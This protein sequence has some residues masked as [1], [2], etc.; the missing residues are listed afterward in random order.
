MKKYKYPV[1]VAFI[2]W[3]FILFLSDIQY[4]EYHSGLRYFYLLRDQLFSVRAPD[5]II[6]IEIDQATFLELPAIRSC[7]AKYRGTID[8]RCFSRRLHG[9]LIRALNQQ[10]AKLIVFNLLFKEGR[11]D[12][13]R[14]FAQ[15][16]READN[17]LLQDYQEKRFIGGDVQIV[18][19][20]PPVSPLA[21][22]TLSAPLPIP[23]GY[24]P[25]TPLWLF[26]NLI[27]TESDAA[28]NITK[29]V[30]PVLAAHALILQ[31]YPTQVSAVLQEVSPDLLNPI[32]D[33]AKAYVQGKHL[34]AF[35]DH[36]GDAFRDKPE[37]GLRWQSVL[38]RHP[39]WGQT[40]LQRLKALSE[41]HRLDNSFYLHPYGPSQTLK[42]IPYQNIQR[43]IQE[44][45]ALFRGKVIFI[46]PSLEWGRSAKGGV[47]E[48]VYGAISSTELAATMLANLRDGTALRS[49]SQPGML[50]LAGLSW[51]LIALIHFLVVA[52][53]AV[54]ILAGLSLSYLA[55]TLLLFSF[56]QLLLP[57]AIIMLQ[58]LTAML[59]MSMEHYFAQREKLAD[60]LQV[61]LPPQVMNLFD[62]Q[63][64]AAMKQGI[65]SQ[66]ICLAADGEGYTKLGETKGERWLAEFMLAYQPIVERC[67]RTHHGI[68]KDWAG[69]GMVAL[70]VEPPT[71]KPSLMNRWLRRRMPE[72]E[73]IRNLALQTA[74]M[75]IDETE[76]FN[77]AQG[78]HFPLRMGLSYGP[79]W[80]SFVDELKVFGDTLNT[81]SRLESLNKDTS[82]HILL[83]QEFHALAKDF[84]IRPLGAFLLRGHRQA[85]DVFELKGYSG[86]SSQ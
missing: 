85:I 13:D 43:M 40:T 2:N 60:L 66:G 6:D 77:Q 74:L 1:M 51:L 22:S 50:M 84:D 71:P 15:A 31:D 70:W 78:V 30:L 7:L 72:A 86:Q 56:D 52:R 38:Y 68:V 62:G 67:V 9:D 18:D 61:S 25:A 28:Q 19:V 54:V 76:R 39:D 8:N 47:I 82:T 17:V 58:T 41:W 63:D 11:G 26:L 44:Q 80:L 69:D 57:W 29:P 64:F 81:A 53:K 24:G 34:H 23:E 12:D 21:E 20:T 83:T 59:S 75:L 73:D 42:T 55:L 32:A 65:H 48:T 33:Y 45:P 14:Y 5:D 49:M 36:I 27:H 16:I 4:F 79:L 35:I 10:G 37:L 46:G 3:V